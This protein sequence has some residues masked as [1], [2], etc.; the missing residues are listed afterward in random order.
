MSDYLPNRPPLKAPEYS[1][2]TLVPPLRM[3]YVDPVWW[4]R[5]AGDIPSDTLQVKDAV[6]GWASLVVLGSCLRK[7]RLQ[8]WYFMSIPD[9]GGLEVTTHAGRPGGPPVEVYLGARDEHHELAAAALRGMGVSITITDYSQVSMN[10]LLELHQERMKD[11]GGMA[12]VDEVEAYMMLVRNA[13][14]WDWSRGQV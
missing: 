12:P 2:P 7:D 6:I 13:G 8:R 1:Y 11:R 14:P 10:R 3:Q 5:T 4:L 9:D